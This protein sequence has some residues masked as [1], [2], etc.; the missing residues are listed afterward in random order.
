MS[1]SPKISM[2]QST[3]I[4]DQARTAIAA[5]PGVVVR[6]AKR[7]AKLN[8]NKRVDLSLKVEVKGRP[9]LILIEAK[10]SGYPRD[11]REAAWQLREL[12]R[13]GDPTPT[14]HMLIAPAISPRSREFLRNEG[15]GYWD[16]GG[17]LHIELPWAFFFIDRPQPKTGQRR[18]TDI[19]RGRTAQVLHAMLLEPERSW[20]VQELSERAEVSPYTVHQVFT[21]LEK[22]LWV[23]KQ[24]KGPNT[25]RTLRDPS[26]LLDDWAN[27]HSL[28]E[29]RFQRFHKWAQSQA[30][31][32]REVIGALNRLNIDYA[33]TLAS[34]AELVA[35]FAT[36]IER[37][38]LLVQD[39]AQ[40]EQAA[41]EMGLTR[42]ESGENVTLL[43][44]RYRSPL[45]FR[46]RIDGAFVAS[47]VQLYLDLWAWPMRG[48]EQAKHLRAERLPY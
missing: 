12:S 38:T 41:K 45:M 25:I 19:Y 47:D 4:L 1:D 27:A 15:F 35:P 8:H 5:L 20:H 14:V 16:Q 31:L 48:K 39:A 32:K 10:A 17:S 2:N 28:E 23:E 33:F 30:D 42:V 40:I 24:G 6:S 26:A 11:V 29:Y 43:D 21:L 7:D 36:G 18:I 44:T 22:Q 13:A 9:A 37:L 3:D 34:G 46:Q